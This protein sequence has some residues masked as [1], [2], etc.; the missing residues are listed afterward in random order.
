MPTFRLKFFKQGHE[1]CSGIAVVLGSFVLVPTDLWSPVKRP[2]S[3]YGFC[4]LTT[5][6]EYNFNNQLDLQSKPDMRF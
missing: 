2:T 1:E 4:W 5:R 6:K 3:F